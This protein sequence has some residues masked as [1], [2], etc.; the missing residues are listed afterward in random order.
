MVL[1]DR[2]YVRPVEPP[3]TPS[4]VRNAFALLPETDAG[5][6]LLL[7]AAEH[8]YGTLLMD[9]FGADDDVFL[10][11]ENFYFHAEPYV[12]RIHIVASVAHWFWLR[13]IRQRLSPRLSSLDYAFSVHQARAATGPV[14]ETALGTFRFARTTGWTCTVSTSVG[15]VDLISYEPTLDVSDEGRLQTLVRS[16][17]QWNERAVAF[18]GQEE[19][20]AIRENGPLVLEAIDITRFTTGEV[21]L[22]YAF[23]RWPDGYLRVRFAGDRPVTVEGGD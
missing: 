15:E 17:D 4:E 14:A 2:L 11:D 10:E 9:S 8:T 3:L 1:R 7:G 18:A 20:P 21:A 6:F 22:E 19:G 5:V 12:E 13:Q 16:L 23:Q